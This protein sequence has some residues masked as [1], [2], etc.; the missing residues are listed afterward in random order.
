MKSNSKVSAQKHLAALGKGAREIS[1]NT[2][3]Y[4]Q[5]GKLYM[6]EDSGNAVG[7]ILCLVAMWL[8]V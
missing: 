2:V 5:G 1:K 3:I 6:I 7:A 8:L 4:K